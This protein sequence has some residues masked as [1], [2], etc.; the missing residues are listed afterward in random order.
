MRAS[1]HYQETDSIAQNCAM[2]TFG[3]RKYESLCEA[4]HQIAQA[5]GL[6]ELQSV[7]HL[8]R[9]NGLSPSKNDLRNITNNRRGSE[10]DLISLNEFLELAVQCERLSCS[11]GM[12]EIMDFFSPF[13]DTGCGCVPSHIF[14]IIMTNAGEAFTTEEIA[15]ILQEFKCV[16]RPDYVDYRSFITSITST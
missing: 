15:D 1:R 4:F 16:D 2:D 10:P 11:Y 12:S 13:D 6:V 7:E 8:L 14:T 5:N 3:V 9:S